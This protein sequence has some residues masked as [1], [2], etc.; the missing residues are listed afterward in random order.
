MK[1]TEL[2]NKLKAFYEAEEKVIVL[3]D[4]S[5]IKAL[6]TDT[7][8]YQ[9]VKRKKAFNIK[10]LLTAAACLLLGVTAGI[11]MFLM[12]E[13]TNNGENPTAFGD[14]VRVE[15]IADWYLPGEFK[16]DDLYIKGEV[17]LE[18]ESVT[19][20]FKL[21]SAGNKKADNE[22]TFPEWVISARNVNDRYIRLGCGWPEYKDVIAEMGHD[23]YY[24]IQTGEIFS[25]C[26][27][28]LASDES[29]KLGEN[30][31]WLD[32]TI[33]E[34]GA[35]T[36]W[37]TVRLG[38]DGLR[39]KVNIET[40]EIQQLSSGNLFEVSADYNYMALYHGKYVPDGK[41]DNGGYK[42]FVIDT[43]TNKTIPITSA[44]DGYAAIYHGLFSPDGKYYL[45]AYN[46]N[47]YDGDTN[48][49]GTY[50]KVFNLETGANFFT[51]GMFKKFTSAGDA[52]I[53][54][55]AANAETGYYDNR[56]IMLSGGADVTDEYKFAPSDMYEVVKTGRFEDCT[57]SLVPLFGEL[58][59][60]V[61]AEHIGCYAEWGGYYYIYVNNSNEVL[62][63]SPVNN[64][65]FSYDISHMG[66]PERK[67]TSIN[68]SVLDSGKKCVFVT[69]YNCLHDPDYVGGSDVSDDISTPEVSLPEQSRPETSI[70]DVSLPDN[71]TDIP[72]KT[73]EYVNIFD[74]QSTVT[75]IRVPLL[76]P[77]YA[78]GLDQWGYL[79][80]SPDELVKTGPM[81]LYWETDKGEPSYD[82]WIKK[83][84]EEWFEDNWLI[85]FRG[86]D[87]NFEVAS[88]GEHIISYSN[89]ERNT[90]LFFIRSDVVPEDFIWDMTYQNYFFIEIAKKDIPY[91]LTDE[92]NYECMGYDIA[93]G[94]GYPIPER[95]PSEG[96]TPPENGTE[97]PDEINFIDI[98]YTAKTI[99]VPLVEPILAAGE[100]QWGRLRTAP[101]DL[102]I[103]GEAALYWETDKGEPSY[104][105][106]I[107]KYT[108]EWFEDNWL[109][110]FTGYESDFD[111]VSVGEH[112]TYKDGERCIKLFFVKSEKSPEPLLWK[113]D[114]TNYYFI[115]IA[116]KDIPYEL[117]D[118]MLFECLYYRRASNIGYVKPEAQ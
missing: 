15:G 35:N 74:I 53:F 86:P 79:Y 10:V 88:I 106:W 64:E 97:K 81:A 75:V 111:I 96:N 26:N 54:Q 107:K 44:D 93:E 31:T 32:L 77:L 92:V 114:Y 46:S 27:R 33:D 83:Y 28:I 9:G 62:I 118:E 58:N 20:P 113:K 49:T 29:Y 108:D 115:E 80:V 78:V 45:Q 110:T 38:W 40:G 112:I 37:C 2:E 4:E 57:L 69:Y 30:L 55:V 41:Y 82:E 73:E 90:K 8:S 67:F 72:E 109:I 34:F 59:T 101:D 5:S 42:T 19:N 76:D 14:V 13:R 117:S 51:R 16:V 22:F 99:R 98:Q 94:Y 87:P 47:K 23:I 52:A 89:G 84:T 95:L 17:D 7:S 50:W 63:Y 3:P 61:I 68:L 103:R 6:N 21:L 102:I 104:E 1:N 60:V 11:S 116:K 56:V 70:P 66:I 85:V 71:S 48:H 24:D 43:R 100:M 18:T 36:Q 91:E 12:T 65:M 105:E 39:F 25:L